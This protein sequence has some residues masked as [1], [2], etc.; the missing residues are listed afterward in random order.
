MKRFNPFEVYKE[1]EDIRDA[2]VKD[3]HVHQNEGAFLSDARED[4]MV[5][6]MSLPSRMP[7][8]S[9]V[10]IGILGML[11]F[12]IGFLQIAR[13]EYYRESAE[14]NRI[15]IQHVEAPRGIFMDR[16]D[17]LLTKNVPNFIATIIPGDLPREAEKRFVVLQR[18]SARL[19]ITA[20]SIEE[21]LETTTKKRKNAHS[22]E[23][24]IVS[25]HIVYETAIVLQAELSDLQGV[26]M[27]VSSLR[28]PLYGEAFSHLL[29]YTGKI[30]EEEKVEKQ[31][32]GY[33]ATDRIGKSGAEYAL[34]SFVRGV[35]GVRQVEVDSRGKEKS[36]IASTASIPGNTIRLSIDAGLQKILYDKLMEEVEKG[37]GIGGAAV[38]MNPETGDILALVSAPGYNP[39]L[40]EQGITQDEYDALT[41]DPTKPLFNRSISG[42]YQSGS[43]IKPFIASAALQEGVITPSTTVQSVGGFSIGQY[44]FPDWKSG[45]HGTTDVRKAIAES[46]NTFFYV[47]GGG[48]DSIAGLGVTRIVEYAQKFGFGGLTGIRLPGEREGLLPTKE[49][50]ENVRPSPWRL[51]DTYHLS[52]GQGDIL[53]TPLQMA[54]GLSTIANGGTRFVPEIIDAI[55]TPEG[56]VV[57]DIAASIE[58]EHVVDARHLQVVREGMR[59]A[60]TG[61][62]ARSLQDL[63]VTSAGKTG[64]AQF[65]TEEKTHAWF[66]GFAPFENPEIVIVVVVEEGGGGHEAALPIAKEGL[67]Y[68]FGG[69]RAEDVLHKIGKAL[70]P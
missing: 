28:E 44:T 63:P 2:H 61:G 16:N 46:V 32:E 58:R 55:L 4:T 21:L 3:F 53:V 29:G 50:R 18:L 6:R 26:E 39:I 8:M 13:G 52:I 20:E 62:S 68:Y 1:A 64:T 34:E 36:V 57:E 60:V 65:G 15:R 24:V 35:Y 42:E 7:L 70:E 41:N 23:P 37:F 54:T 14:I 43:T 66:T 9:I 45:G 67:Q 51:G 22:F 59:Q 12:R 11:A 69:A 30:S 40:F 27:R 47:I 31:Q 49:W 17:I 33:I 48:K 56:A 5:K 25:D 19:G 10:V 38:A